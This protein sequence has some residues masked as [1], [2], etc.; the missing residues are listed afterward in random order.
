M[1]ALKR[2]Y[3]PA[4]QPRAC[5]CKSLPPS[6]L[7]QL[8]ACQPEC[9][10]SLERAYHPACLLLQLTACQLACSCKSQPAFRLWQLTAC[11]MW[12]PSLA[13]KSLQVC[14]TSVCLFE[15]C[16]V[17]L[18]LQIWRVFL[19]Q[20]RIFFPKITPAKVQLSPL[21][22]TQLKTAHRL[23]SAFMNCDK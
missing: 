19:R 9:M 5:S 4:S 21:E 8:T 7:W 15:I 22:H 12:T 18:H 17:V 10:S 3:K 13:A 1:S 16:L 11:L 2:A 14:L 6:L 20:H 23:C